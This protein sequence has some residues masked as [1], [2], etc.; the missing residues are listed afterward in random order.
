MNPNFK[1]KSKVKM[2]RIKLFSVMAIIAILVSSCHVTEYIP[3]KKPSVRRESY[4]FI[5]IDP[6]EQQNYTNKS[7]YDFQKNNMEYSVIVRDLA[8]RTSQRLQDASLSQAT[9]TARICQIIEQALLRSNY[10]VR[11]R[12]LFEYITDKAETDQT[13]SKLHEKTGVDVIFEVTS[14]NWDPYDF[15]SYYEENT[16]KYFDPENHE[17]VYTMYGFSIEIKVI[18][19]KNNIVGG[20]YKYSYTPCDATK[21]GC[22]LTYIDE[23]GIR[24]IPLESSKTVISKDDVKSSLTNNEEMIA[25]YEKAISEFISDIV[26]PGIDADIKNSRNTKN[27]KGK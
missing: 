8:N 18:L 9:T 16:K 7:L 17:R 3:E 15:N 13:Y 25:K 23:D 5:K 12:Q 27:T 20:T 2:K 10:K 14:L 26:I 22:L 4:S 1:I 21:G 11:D 19:L 24:Y 6:V